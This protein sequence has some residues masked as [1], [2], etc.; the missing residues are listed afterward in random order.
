MFLITT[1]SVAAG[2]FVLF[3]SGAFSGASRILSDD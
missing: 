2:Q 3:S 1:C